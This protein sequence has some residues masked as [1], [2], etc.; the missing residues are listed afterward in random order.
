M[1]TDVRQ[2]TISDLRPEH[3]PEVA[4]IYGEGIA[5]GDATFETAVPSWEDWDS[6]HLEAHRLVALDED[7]V[8]GW[9]AVSPVSDR[10]VY[11]GVVENSVYVA[12]DARGQGIGRLLLEHLISSTE[13]AGVW[14]IQTGI[15][16]ENNGSVHLHEQVGFEVVGRRKKLGKL[17]GVWRDVLLL[18]RRSP[19][20]AEILQ[21]ITAVD[22]L[23]D[24][25][26]AP[27]RVLHAA[28]RLVSRRATR[29]SSRRCCKT[30]AD[31]QRLGSSTSS[32]GPRARRLRLRVPADPR[33]FAADG[34]PPSE[35]AD[36]GRLAR[37]GEARLFRL[38]PPCRRGARACCGCVPGHAH[39][40]LAG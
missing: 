10:C 9:A 15:F 25:R 8:V 24:A 23:A 20:S 34:Q 22:I 5:T 12:E 33:R 40:L 32:C 19:R 18:E 37:A 28:C 21:G 26:P 16:P 36:R 14:T 38:L 31:R 39:G 17:H 35:G 11:G 7:G 6:S 2:I 13:E 4:R 30:L 3:W 29:Q 27:R 1:A